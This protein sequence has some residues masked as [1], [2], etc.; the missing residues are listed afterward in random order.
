VIAEV[1]GWV[2]FEI[3]GRRRLPVAEGEKQMTVPVERHAPAEVIG[4]CCFG[5]K[6]LF[7][8]DEPV[9]L[10]ASAHDCSRGV[11]AEVF[12][13]TQIQQ[14]VV[15]EFRVQ[16]H[17]EQP[18]LAGALIKHFRCSLYRLRQQTPVADDSQPAGSLGDKHVA[19]WQPGYRPWL[20]DPV[21]DRDSLIPVM[22]RIP[23]VGLRERSQ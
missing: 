13:E 15:S 1:L 14:T 22:R 20:D 3:A 12:R 18:R 23:Q 10:E 16:C 5:G 9:T 6:D 17:V 21:D 4:T 2:G 11:I 8:I 7:D 19:V